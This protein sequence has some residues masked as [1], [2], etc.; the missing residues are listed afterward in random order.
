M[1]SA[2]DITSCA[3]SNFNLPPRQGDTALA[4]ADQFLQALNSIK[5]ELNQLLAEKERLEKEKSERLAQQASFEADF[6]AAQADRNKTEQMVR[7][8][9]LE[10][11]DTD[12]PKILDYIKVSTL[13]LNHDSW[14]LEFHD[15]DVSAQ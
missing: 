3:D 15:S 6:E 8:M 13:P 7:R 11:Q 10:Q 5:V 14:G 1:S 9:R 12:Q 2:S 4:T